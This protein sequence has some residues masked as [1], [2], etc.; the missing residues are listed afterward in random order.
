MSTVNEVRDRLTD[1]IDK[2]LAGGGTLERGQWGVYDDGTQHM[3]CGK[4]ACVLGVFLREEMLG[5]EIGIPVGIFTGWR[6]ELA[7][8]KLGITTRQV[9]HIIQG[10]DEG[11]VANEWMEL[12]DDLGEKYLGPIV[13]YDDYEDL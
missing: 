13:S 1:A 10:F 5:Q 9:G 7:A 12:G 6:D 3:A 8:E 4:G 11:D 2:Y